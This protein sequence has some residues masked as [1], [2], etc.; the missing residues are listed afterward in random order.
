MVGRDD[1]M[2]GSAVRRLRKRL[3]MSRTKLAVA[4]GVDV[5]TITRWETL[6]DS[7][8]SHAQAA[9]AAYASTRELQ[10]R[11]QE[12]EEVCATLRQRL[13]AYEQITIQQHASESELQTHVRQLKEECAGLRQRLDI[14]EQ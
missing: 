10:A 12:L 4:L 3:C 5:S 7:I 9:L 11:V 6:S 8:P 13:R 14:Y 2:N 1:I